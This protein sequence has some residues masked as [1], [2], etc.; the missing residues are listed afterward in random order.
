MAI[1]ACFLNICT[2]LYCWVC[3]LNNIFWKTRSFYKTTSLTLRGQVGG[4][5]LSIR[6]K[7]HLERFLGLLLGIQAWELENS[8]W[9]I[10]N[11]NYWRSSS[12][13]SV[14]SARNLV[15]TVFGVTDWDSGH[16][17]PKFKMADSKWR[18]FLVKFAVFVQSARNLVYKGLWARWLRFWPRNRK[19]QDRGSKMGIISSKHRG[20]SFNRHEVT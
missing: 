4:L 1:S 10:K 14:L 3:G 9:R 18:R 12:W 20:F 6:T 7:F 16:R 15:W 5:F 8:W 13:F 2:R 11:D 19:F 17:I